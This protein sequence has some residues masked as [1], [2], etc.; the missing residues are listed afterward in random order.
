[1]N[2]VIIILVISNFYLLSLSISFLSLF[3][4]SFIDC[5]N[6]GL[7]FPLV[8]IALIGKTV[9]VPSACLI[10]HCFVALVYFSFDET[11][12]RFDL[13]YY[14]NLLTF[15]SF[16]ILYLPDLSEIFTIFHNKL[17]VFN[18]LLR[19]FVESFF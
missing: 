17:L 9:L 13:I 14:S 8:C 2:L 1:M 4:S 7:P 3:I 11:H 6:L 5:Y 16:V 15:R 19:M 18:L 12:T 10:V